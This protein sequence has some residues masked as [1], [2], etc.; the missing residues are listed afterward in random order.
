MY[1]NPL[2]LLFLTRSDEAE[3]SSDEE[4][5]DEDFSSVQFGSRYL[6]NAVT[7]A[8]S[9]VEVLTAL[10]YSSIAHRRF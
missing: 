6:W 5:D 4:N 8:C 3:D 7:L 2:S 9:R 1:D 10:C